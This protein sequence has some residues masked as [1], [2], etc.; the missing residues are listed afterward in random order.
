[1]WSWIDTVWSWITANATVFSGLTSVG[2]L[3][4]WGIYLQLI[5]HNFRMQRRPQIIINRG[6]GRDINSLCLISNM[7]QEAV[8][9]ET[10]FAQL[11]TSR[12]SWFIDI[13]DI[14]DEHAGRHDQQN[15]TGADTHSLSQM[16]H[17]GPLNKGQYMESGTF[18]LLI[19]RIAETNGLELNETCRPRPTDVE[20]YSLSICLIAVFGNE[21]RPIGARRRFRL[22]DDEQGR[23]SLIPDEPGTRQL[24]SR[25]HR[26]EIR[27]W[28]QALL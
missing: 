9:I 14:V 3:L 21:K 1:M 4:I 2:M 6:R 24:N 13:T 10:I 27:R 16:T 12:G 5:L 25:R 8:F 19:R 18:G 22:I 26:L 20:L 15:Q 7:S 17:Q 28:Q 23:L 11:E